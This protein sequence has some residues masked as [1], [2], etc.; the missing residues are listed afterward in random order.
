MNAHPKSGRVVVGTTPA[1]AMWAEMDKIYNANPEP[2]GAEWFTIEQ[3]AARY[4]MSYNGAVCR[5]R[6][7][8]QL[9]RWKGMAGSPAR[10]KI[11]YR[12]KP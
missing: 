1:E 10:L 2:M 5:L 4:G 8:K 3:F 9:E 7:D 6:E 12:I 11:K